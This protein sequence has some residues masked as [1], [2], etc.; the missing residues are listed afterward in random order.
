MRTFIAAILLVLTSGACAQRQFH[1]FYGNI[2]DQSTLRPVVDVN[3]TFQGLK[4]GYVSDKKGEFSFFLDTIP[5]YMIISYMGYETKK[6]WLDG[7]SPKLNIRLSPAALV[8]GEV[9]IVAKAGPDIFYKD[10]SYAVLDYEPDSSRVYILIFR[11]TLAEAELICKTMDGKLLASAGRFPFKPDSLFRDCLGNV[12]L[13]CHD[14]AYQVF[15]DSAGISLVYPTTMEKFET[16]LK[17]CVASTSSKLFFKKITNDGFGIDFYRVDRVTR[18][19]EK[20]ASVVDEENLSRLRRNQ[21]DYGRIRSSTIPDGRK[22][23]EEWNF[24]KKIMYRPR[25]A[26]MV[27]IGASICIFNSA[28]MTIEFYTPEG[29]FTSKVRLDMSKVS[30]GKWTKEIYVDEVRKKAYTSFNRNGEFTIYRVDLETGSLVRSSRLVHI[31]PQRIKVND[32]RAFYMY[33]VPGEPDNKQ[34][35]KQTLSGS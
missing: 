18:T 29:E 1:Y 11:S 19:N 33:N 28:D 26:T 2:I 30:D 7:T 4:M 35:F 9:E 17:N 3:I 24:A 6:I 22:E 23:F 34:L 16:V 14:S 25:T 5:V 20:M 13:L 27:R 10:P 31:F 21:D 15:T 8:L 32:G 12:H